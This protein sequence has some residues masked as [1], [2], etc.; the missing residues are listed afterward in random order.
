MSTFISLILCIS[1]LNSLTSRSSLTGSSFP[2]PT[3]SIACSRDL[4]GR[5]SMFLVASMIS[6]AGIAVSTHSRKIFSYHAIISF[7]YS[8]WG[9]PFT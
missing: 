8:S 2:S 9:T 5:P 6:R 1:S 4:M 7:R 3:S